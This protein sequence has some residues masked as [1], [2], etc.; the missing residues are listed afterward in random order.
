MD[1]K[2]HK[3]LLVDDRQENLISLAAV[4]KNDGYETDQCLSG[5]EALQHLLK[6]NYGLIILDVQMPG[7]DGFELAELIK[8]N[9]KTKFIPLIFLSANATQPDFFQKGHE[10]GALDYLTKP[11]NE[12][13]LLAKVK[14][15]SEVYHA[16]FLKEQANKNLT[17]KVQ[18]ANISYRM[19]YDSLP[20]D[21]LLINR[22]GIV[23]NIN[24]KDFLCFGHPIHEILD[25]P[26]TN[27]PFLQELFSRFDSQ[28][29][30]PVF[31]FIEHQHE[32]VTMEFSIEPDEGKK[33]YGEA[34]ITMAMIDGEDCIQLSIS[35]ITRRKEIEHELQRSEQ[36]IRSFAAYLNKATEDQRTHL[37]REI[38]DELGQQLAGI[39]F[40]I[41]SLRKSMAGNPGAESMLSEIV[42]DVEQTIQSL[43]K[44]ATELR[45]GILDTL[46]LAASIQW[47]M[48]EFN[49]KTK[50]DC[51]VNLEVNEHQFS[52]ELSTCFFRICQ[53]ALSNIAKHA[54]ASKVQVHL[55]I[56]R[57]NIHM[58]IHD[59]GK[60]IQSTKQNNPF[61]M[62]L[63]GMKERATGQGG[64][65]EIQSEPLKGT[66][67][68]I[69]APIQHNL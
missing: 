4:L 8:G 39:K 19:L 62:G 57:N 21:V 14:N 36:Q 65:F 60:G 2:Q 35:N 31:C 38:H 27:T 58:T 9:S 37:A 41:S 55:F 7:M 15:F 44:I 22:S 18:L 61:S 1:Y 49:K 48:K 56:V 24:R 10:T 43:R 45:P 16:N 40:G 26:Y 46:G 34:I 6:Q 51:K 66:T 42:G 17:K 11:I 20:Q 12:S 23:I 68:D 47:L 53:E 30:D 28:G 50:I 59:N 25:Q 67:I 52:K 32:P 64:T 13:L 29:E 33:C 63:L 3:I 69:S 54:D 5:I